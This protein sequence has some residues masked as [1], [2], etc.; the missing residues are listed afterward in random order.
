MPIMKLG[1]VCW[2]SR[3]KAPFV[4]DDFGDVGEYSLH[5]GI[6]HFFENIITNDN[7]HLI[8]KTTK[9]RQDSLIPYKGIV[10]VCTSETKGAIPKFI[11]NDTKE[12]IYL[13][14]EQYCIMVIDK[15]ISPEFLFYW[16]KN[17]FE[18]FRKYITG[19]AVY[20]IH[21]INFLNVK[22]NVP[23]LQEQ[24]EIVNANNET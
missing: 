13:G 5:Y 16:L 1:D 21:P 18:A 14:G 10:I 22:F 4:K 15:I 9:T 7:I 3:G 24:K 12:K 11:Y 2:V 6:S 19:M 17:N 8:P 20:R 23:S